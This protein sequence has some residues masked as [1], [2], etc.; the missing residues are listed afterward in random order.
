MRLQKDTICY[1]YIKGQEDGNIE[2]ISKYMNLIY[3]PSPELLAKKINMYFSNPRLVIGQ[4][5]LTAQEHGF[6]STNWGK[7]IVLALLDLL[8][9]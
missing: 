2:L 8:R 5:K 6:V 1:S 7:E 9:E 4:K 3:E